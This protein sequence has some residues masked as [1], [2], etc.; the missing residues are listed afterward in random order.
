MNLIRNWFSLTP[1][2]RL[3]RTVLHARCLLHDHKYQWHLAGI[4]REVTLH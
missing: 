1:E 4:W 2:G 3:G